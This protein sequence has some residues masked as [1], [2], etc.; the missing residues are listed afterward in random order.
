MVD[1][2]DRAGKLK[3]GSGEF[4]LVAGITNEMAFGRAEIAAHLNEAITAFG[5]AQVQDDFSHPMTPEFIAGTG[6]RII[7]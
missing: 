5:F 2:L 3:P 4:N 7:W 6:L 1:G